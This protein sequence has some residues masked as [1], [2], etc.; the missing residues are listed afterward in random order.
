MEK[1]QLD[2][3]TYDNQLQQFI[4]LGD[5]IRLKYATGKYS[6]GAMIMP[7]SHYDAAHL[8]L[9]SA[10]VYLP[11]KNFLHHVIS[12]IWPRQDL[13]GQI[14]VIPYTNTPNHYPYQVS[15]FYTVQFSKYSPEQNLKVTIT[16]KDQRSHQ[17]HT[18]ILH[19]Y[20]PNQCPPPMQYS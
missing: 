20:T 13:K 9:I 19:I 12:D 1:V 16:T 3:S 17:G 8:H 7:R 2:K 15:T 11:S 14:K 18:M 10:A 4:C 5:Q 6:S